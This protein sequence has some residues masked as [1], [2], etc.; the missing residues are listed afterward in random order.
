MRDWDWDWDWE[1]GK[2]KDLRS[3]VSVPVPVPVS[4]SVSY[5]GIQVSSRSN[6]PLLRTL[7]PA[8][9]VFCLL[10]ALLRKVLQMTHEPNSRRVVS[11]NQVSV[12]C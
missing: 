10:P 6:D 8:A 5:P 11:R 3:T 4:V 7:R 2:Q 9:S 12:P 1:C